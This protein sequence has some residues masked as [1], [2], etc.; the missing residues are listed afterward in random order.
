M[1]MFMSLMGKGLPST[2]MF[3]MLMGTLYKQF[4]EKEIDTFQDFHQA[5]LDIFITVNS[6]LPGKH[7]DAPS[8]KEVEDCYNTWKQSHMSERKDVFVDFMTKTLNLSML[9]DTT[10]ITG[11]V[12]PPAAMAA[13]KAGENVPQ[14]RII[15]AIPNVIFVPSITLMAIIAAKLSRKIIQRKR[16]HYSPSPQPSFPEAPVPPAHKPSFPEEAVPPASTS[17]SPPHKQSFPEEVPTVAVPPA[18]TSSSPPHKPSFPETVPP[19]EKP[20]AST[21]SSPPRKP[22]FPVPPKEPPASTS[23]SSL[24]KPTFPKEKTWS[25][26]SPTPQPSFP[27]E[28]RKPQ[29]RNSRS[30]H[31]RHPAAT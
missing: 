6:A 24:R 31:L 30:R 9:D 10:M 13:K 19:E 27:K 11:I 14:M 8:R 2:Q 17:S 18:S 21:S 12:T 4:T 7:Y 16:S 29:L 25:W 22:S 15:K 28:E 1:G 5:F 23:S 3:N 26:Y 20:P